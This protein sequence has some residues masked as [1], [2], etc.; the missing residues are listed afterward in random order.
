MTISL[1][2]LTGSESLSALITA[3]QSWRTKIHTAVNSGIDGTNNITTD[4][5]AETNMADDANV[6]LFLG[7]LFQR[8]FNISLTASQTSGL[9][10][11]LSTGVAY[12]YDATGGKLV[13]INKA[14]TTAFTVEASKD[15]YLDLGSDGVLDLNAVSNGAAAPSVASNHLRLSKVVSGGSAITSITDLTPSG[16]VPVLGHE[17]HMLTTWASGSDTVSVHGGQIMFES[18][19]LVHDSG[20]MSIDITQNTNWI[21]GTSLRAANTW[22]YVYVKNDGSGGITVGLHTSTPNS[23]DTSGNSYGK[24]L[25]RSFSGTYWR[26]IGAVLDNA[27]QVLRTMGS[28]TGGFR[29]YAT[30]MTELSAGTSASFVDV[31][32]TSAMPAAISRRAILRL[33]CSSATGDSYHIRADGTGHADGQFVTAYTTRITFADVEVTSGIIEY[34]TTGGAALTID[35]VGYVIDELGVW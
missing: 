5:V 20:I 28:Q 27:S 26:C 10:G 33:T 34:K 16:F 2:A 32:M 12:V 7:Q 23:S 25:Y 29:Y 4:T 24:S 35:V 9:N 14:S 3:L 11:Q 13:R 6:Q 30:Q 31:D 19:L 15:T 22:Y 21:G 17:I 18:T 8:G 1:D